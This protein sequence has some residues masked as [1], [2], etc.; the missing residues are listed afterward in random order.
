M[1]LGTA[2]RLRLPERSY[3]RESRTAFVLDAGY[4]RVNRRWLSMPFP[5]RYPT[6]FN[7]KRAS[8]V[9]ALLYDSPDEEIEKVLPL[10]AEIRKRVD[11]DVHE[12]FDSN[13]DFMLHRKLHGLYIL[14]TLEIMFLGGSISET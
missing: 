13:L 7:N 1:P 6:E 10:A 12:L 9:D 5:C 14:E 3:L 4:P 11:P 8:K 2:Y